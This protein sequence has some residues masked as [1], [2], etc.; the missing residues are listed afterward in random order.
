MHNVTFNSLFLSPSIFVTLSHLSATESD[1]AAA[2][3][4]QLGTAAETQGRGECFN[5][6]RTDSSA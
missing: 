3:D 1:R 2:R 4:S 5:E 6:E